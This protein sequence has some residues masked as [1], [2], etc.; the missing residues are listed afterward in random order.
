MGINGIQVWP[1]AVNATQD[2]SGTDVS[3][4]PAQRKNIRR[5]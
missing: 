5:E 3:L 2:K 1:I 4:I